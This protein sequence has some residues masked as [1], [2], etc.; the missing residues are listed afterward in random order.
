[1]SEIVATYD[2]YTGMNADDRMAVMEL[3]YSLMY[4]RFAKKARLDY[5]RQVWRGLKV[6]DLGYDIQHEVWQ[7]EG[8]DAGTLQILSW[9]H[10]RLLDK[11]LVVLA[12]V[13]RV[14]RPKGEAMS[15]DVTPMMIARAR[16]YPIENVLAAAGIAVGRNKMCLCQFHDDTNPSMSVGKYNR[17]NCFTCGEKGGVIDLY[18]RLAHKQLPEAVKF[19]AGGG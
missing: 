2:P 13:K 10:S 18:M 11:M 6:A 19:L 5:L 3:K 15:G 16:E 7:A 1:M 12:E 14:K 8:V 4:E 9:L 17:F